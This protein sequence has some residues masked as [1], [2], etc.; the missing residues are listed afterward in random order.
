MNKRAHEWPR[1]SSAKCDTVYGLKEVINKSF[2][3]GL[4]SRGSESKSEPGSELLC[5]DST[6][7]ILTKLGYF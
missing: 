4:W 5:T 2:S 1:Q 3:P 7:L 6:A